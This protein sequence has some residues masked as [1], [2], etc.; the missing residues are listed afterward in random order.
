MTDQIAKK[1]LIKVDLAGWE[2][3][4]WPQLILNAF[5]IEKRY[6]SL[7]IGIDLN[8][9]T[10]IPI[11]KQ[12]IKEGI[13]EFLNGYSTTVR[14]TTVGLELLADEGSE[15]F[16]IPWREMSAQNLPAIEKARETL[17]EWEKEFSDEEDDE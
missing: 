16:V 9:D 10:V 6:G 12:I 14:I 4:N 8:D 5:T 3:G 11:V 17:I 2:W 15:P 13:E 7:E 1:A